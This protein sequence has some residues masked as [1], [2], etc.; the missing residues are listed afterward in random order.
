M[1][2]LVDLVQQEQVKKVPLELLMD[3]EEEKI[4]LKEEL[5]V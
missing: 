3:Q 2:M 1:E 4:I 5:Q